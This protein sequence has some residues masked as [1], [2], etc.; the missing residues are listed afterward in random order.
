MLVEKDLMAVLFK[1]YYYL[2]GIFLDVLFVI[3]LHV[4][5]LLVSCIPSDDIYTT[6]YY[7]SY[8][9]SPGPSGPF[10]FFKKHTVGV[11]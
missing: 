9:L 10:L 7:S 8:A 6:E 1:R 3:I 4:K 2:F 11:G 5:V